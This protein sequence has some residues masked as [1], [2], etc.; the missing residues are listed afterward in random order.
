MDRQGREVARRFTVDNNRPGTDTFIRQLAQRVIEGDF[1]AVQI[2]AEA[3]GWSWW[4]F[5]QTLDQA[6]GLPQ[7]PVALYPLNPRLTANC[8]KTSVDLDHADPMDAFVIADRLRL[9]RDLPPPFHS[10]ARSFPVR[11][12]TRYRSHVVHAWAREKAYCLAIRSLKASESTR[13]APFSNVFGAA[14]RAILQECAA[15]EDIA[16]LPLDDLVELLDQA[17]KRRFADPTDNARRLQQ[18]ARDSSCLPDALHQPIH[19]SWGLSLQHVT[20]LERQ[21]KRLDTAMAEGMTAIPHTLDTLPGFGPVF[22]GGILTEVGGLERFHSNA[23]KVAKFAGVKWH[24]HQSAA[25]QADETPLTRTGNRLLRYSFCEAAN[26]VRR[27][28][29]QYAAYDD[30]TYHEVRTHRQKRALV[31]T[32]RKLVRLVVRLL[33]TNQPYQPRRET[34]S[35]NDTNTWPPGHRRL[36]SWRWNR[37]STVGSEQC[38]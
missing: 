32:A 16:A 4:H 18:V 24:R 7:W 14:S 28:D 8:K 15:L 36:S 2:A 19:L 13:L 6:P 11:C 31:L 34:S 23:A 27:R 38:A 3:T 5:F 37:G 33:T 26:A 29:P 12:L 30:R 25:F 35:A 1:D 21:V 17:G 9:G 22:S 20:L 10:E